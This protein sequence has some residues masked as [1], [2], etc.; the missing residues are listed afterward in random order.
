M[1]DE[2]RLF[3]G[4]GASALAV[5]CLTWMKE[6]SFTF[7]GMFTVSCRTLGII[8]AIIG[9]WNLLTS[10][11]FGDF[12]GEVLA[13]PLR[14]LGWLV[15]YWYLAVL[16]VA[17][18]F[19]L[20]PDKE[21][22]PETTEFTFPR[23][24][25][26]QETEPVY[27]V[28]PVTATIPVATTPTEPPVIQPYPGMHRNAGTC[29]NLTRNAQ[30]LLVF[31]N[32]SASNWSQQE[33]QTF[34]TDLVYPGLDYIEYQAGKYGYN[35]VLETC[36]YPDDAGNAR[37][38]YYDGTVADWDSAEP[39][40]DL[41]NRARELY[42][43]D[44]NL[45]M[46]ENVNSYGGVDQTAVVFCLDKPGRSYANWHDTDNSYVEQAVVFTSMN[47]TRS[48]SDL[49]AHEVMHLFGA[50]DLYANGGERENRAKLAG[51]WHPAE[52][53]YQGRWNIYENTICAYNAYAV[54]WLDT[55]PAEYDI[56]EWWS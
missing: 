11:G 41:V 55:L 42:G 17:L 32:D 48:R 29:K 25:Y 50:D 36:W 1:K 37:I 9:G 23:Q 10:D 20:K 3:Y 7:L 30:V 31:V 38:L 12:V 46:V 15:E 51:Q 13:F 49:I 6:D 28:P 26:L 14:V 16:I 56:P 24:T 54:G 4:I 47:G 5:L 33:I 39:T 21:E 45:A 2:N 44:S 27:T 43:F 52:L 8:L 40:M 35:I 18:V 34:M 19:W 22:P 53:F